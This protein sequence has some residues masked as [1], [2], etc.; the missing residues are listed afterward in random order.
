MSYVS[1][2]LLTFKFFLDRLMLHK[3]GLGGELF[4]APV[5]PILF[6]VFL[7]P[8]PEN[9]TNIQ[10]RFAN[11]SL[12]DQPHWPAGCWGS[13]MLPLN[14][15]CPLDSSSFFFFFKVD[16]KPLFG[17]YP[18]LTNLHKPFSIFLPQAAASRPE[19]EDPSS[20]RPCRLKL[21]GLFRL[22]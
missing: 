15:L 21:T 17:P 18:L 19:M 1:W 5:L 20:G 11:S 22:R 6:S 2:S 9:E 4:W 13:Q 16:Q 8:C 3:I 7:S 10:S 12:D 14:L